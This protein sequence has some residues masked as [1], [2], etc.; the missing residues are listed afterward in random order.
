MN[1]FAVSFRHR[2]KRKL[3]LSNQTCEFLRVPLSSNFHTSL[4]TKELKAEDKYGSL[5]KKP[6]RRAS[7][8]DRRFFCSFMGLSHWNEFQSKNH[9]VLIIAHPAVSE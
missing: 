6:L 1:G 9:W 2:G 8:F 3:P 7:I 4:Y 5:I